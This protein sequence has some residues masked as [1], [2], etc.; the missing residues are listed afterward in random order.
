MRSFGIVDDKVKEAEFFLTQLTGC[1]NFFEARCYS[2][3]FAAAT[4]SI[5][6]ALQASLRDLPGFS[7]WYAAK[8]TQLKADSLARFFHDFRRVS[9]HIGEHVI[10]GGTFSAGKMLFYF[11]AKKGGQKRGHGLTLDKRDLTARGRA[12]RES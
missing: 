11:R 10:G 8:Q 6:F 9:H 4:R 5:T 3:A 2:V 1:N 12:W 7:H